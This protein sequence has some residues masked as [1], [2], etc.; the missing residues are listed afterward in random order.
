MSSPGEDSHL[1]EEEDILSKEAS[2]DNEDNISSDDAGSDSDLDDDSLD[3]D[4]GEG[5]HSKGV[6]TF[7]APEEDNYEIEQ[8]V[9]IPEHIKVQSH[10]ADC[11]CH[12]KEDI[13]AVGSINGPVVLHRYATAD[14]DNKEVIMFD[15]HKKNC[16]A[17]RF[18]NSGEHLFTGAKDNSIYVVDLQSNSIFRQFGRPDGSP[19]YTILPIDDYI[20]ASGEE[21]GESNMHS[22]LQNVSIFTVYNLFATEDKTIKFATKVGLLSHPDDSPNAPCPQCGADCKVTRDKNKKLGFFYTCTQMCTGTREV[23]LPG[24]PSNLQGQ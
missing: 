10:I 21:D 13:V 22:L 12:P 6:L 16:R 9:E 17:V 15:H 14:T 20:M 7:N 2:D 8:N 4:I 18:S 23:D 11:C 1:D 3:L 19:V 5:D 24:P